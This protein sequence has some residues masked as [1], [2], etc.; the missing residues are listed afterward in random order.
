MLGIDQ[1]WLYFLIAEAI[2]QKSRI[3]VEGELPK[4]S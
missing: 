1:E 3:V 2:E 4:L